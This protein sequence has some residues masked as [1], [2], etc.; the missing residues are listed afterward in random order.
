[1]TASPSVRPS[2]PPSALRVHLATDP[3]GDSGYRLDEE[4]FRAAGAEFPETFARL[5]PTYS[6]DEAGFRRGVR[7]A[8]VLIGWKFPREGLADLAPHLR[9]V[10]LIGAGVD[11][12]YPLDWLPRKAK[13]LTASG[14]HTKKCFEYVLMALVALRTRLPRFVVSQARREWTKIQTGTLEG[15]TALVIGLGAVG[16]GAAEA[17]RTLG[18]RVLGVRRT[19]RP[20]RFVDELFRPEELPRALP[21]ADHVVLAAPLTG[22]TAEIL[23][24]EEIALLPRGAGVVNLG[25]GRLLSQPALVAAL[26]SGQV[27]GAFLD[28]VWP[29][30]LPP[31]SDLWHAP[32]LILTPHVGADDIERYVPMVFR[33]A[34]DNL[35][36]F[37]A[38]KPQ[39]NVV[40]PGRGY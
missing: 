15:K 24:A 20:H 40:N 35:T 26:R 30:P 17:A 22:E 9:W 28:T 18:M 8:E 25:R 38:G 31:E 10:Q 11:H 6:D 21:R 4:R 36:R 39:R 5:R 32:N 29:E 7:D 14:V 23:G 34:L 16:T 13:L 1:M 33:I 3:G 2:P 19:A 27:G 12:L 37:F